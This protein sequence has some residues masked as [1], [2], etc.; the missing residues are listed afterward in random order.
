[1][2]D[3]TSVPI[4][5]YSLAE[6]DKPRFLSELRNALIN[7]G[8]LYLSNTSIPQ[9]LVEK[10]KSYLDPLFALPQEEKDRIRMANSQHFLGYNRLG[11]EFT[12]G[13]QDMREQFDFATSHN[14]RWKSGDEEYLKLWGQAQW[15]S[16]ELLPGFKDDF[17]AYL[18]A[19][20]QLS[21]KFTT[22]VSEALG[23]PPGGLDK[24]FDEPRAEV[25]Q[26][27]GKV[28]RYP[29]VK[30]GQS[31]QGVGPH[32][33]GSFLTFVSYWFDHRTPSIHSTIITASSS[34]PA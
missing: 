2:T 34:F 5:D 28:V 14:C 15:P 33:D 21:Y 12:K 19:L 30:P 13:A 1:M 7:V 32:F 10:V 26:H 9:E 31:D 8:F 6:T 4:I 17:L 16:N 22:Y 24:F 29:P 3:F 23:L 18:S 20:E 25:M 27:R 11:S